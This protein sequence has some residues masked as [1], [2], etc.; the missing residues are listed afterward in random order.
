VQNTTA[1]SLA[2]FARQRPALGAWLVPELRALTTSRHKSVRGR[3]LQLLASLTA[4]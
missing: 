2:H 4:R 1:E 3:A